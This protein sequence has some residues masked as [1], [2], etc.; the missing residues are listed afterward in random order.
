MEFHALV[1]RR[2]SIRKYTAER[3]DPPALDRILQAVARA[4][5]AGN[6]Q[7][8]HIVVVRSE[9]RRR[10][11]AAAAGAQ[12]FLGEAPVDLV[13]FAEP[14]RSAVRYG[15]RGRSLYAVQDA[16]I[17]AT[18]AILAATDEGLSSVWVGA[19][20]EVAVQAIC[21]RR[22]SRPVA[23]VAIGHGAEDPPLTPRR[24]LRQT[25]SEV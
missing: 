16:T 14:D 9:A 3:V 20:E 12:E 10:A 8:Y 21:G 25:V 24:P 1:Q 11:L 17:A 13:F 5:S 22:R 4:P 15:D 6:L 7:A 2:R 19:F 18:Y 23:I